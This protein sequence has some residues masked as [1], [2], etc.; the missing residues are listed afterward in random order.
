MQNLLFKL[1][2]MPTAALL[3]LAAAAGSLAFALVMQYGFGVLPCELCLWQRA[4]FAAAA[5]LALI[6]AVAR[7]FG[8]HTKVL[9]GLS[10]ALFFVNTGLAVFHSGVERHWWEFNSACTGSALDRVKSVED[11][12]RELL[13][14]PAVRCDEI[15]WSLFGLSMAN[16]NIAFSFALG[17]FAAAAAAAAARRK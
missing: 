10:A 3:I 12:R 17:L 15:S 1:L 5:L 11:M 14:K 2:A 16:F 4:P 7:P 8:K 9:L 13:G 6:A